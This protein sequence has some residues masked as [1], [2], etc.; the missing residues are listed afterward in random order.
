M[1][2]ILPL[3][4]VN[5]VY[6]SFKRLLMENAETEALR[7]A[8][9][10]S[11]NLSSEN[12]K[13]RNSFMSLNFFVESERI[14]KDLQ[15][16]KLKTFSE[17]GEITYS[18]DPKDIGTINTKAY[19]HNIVAKGNVYTKIVQKGTD[20][21][22]NNKMTRD[23][24]E[25][26][27]PIMNGNQ[28]IG[29]FEIYYDITVAK[30]KVDKQILYSSLIQ[31][32]VAF[33]LFFAV[34]TALLN[35]NK[36]ITERKM[37]EEKL[38]NS[39]QNLLELNKQLEKR[40][41]DLNDARIDAE[42]ANIAKSEFLANM[43]HEVR[44]PM[45]AIIGMTELTLDTD[46][47]T[48]Q[49]EYIEIVRVSSSNLLEMVNNIFDFSKIEAGKLE[50]V[51]MDFNIANVVEN[52][53][54]V[55]TL[56]ALDKGLDLT[57]HINDDLPFCLK[58]D[59]FRL[60]QIITHLVGN[61]VKFTERGKII[62]RVEKDKSETGNKDNN[63]QQLQLHFSVADTGIGIPKDKIQGIFESFS[64][65]DGTNTR[66]YGGAGLGLAIAKEL[67]HMMNGDIWVESE[68]EKGTTLHFSAQFGF[69]NEP[70]KH[71]ASTC[72]DHAETLERPVGDEIS[73][74]E[75]AVRPCP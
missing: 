64:Q 32:F 26:Y 35:A 34:I 10:L 23:V 8:T 33:S 5:I 48:E 29:A 6:P 72:I 61:A 62:V 1:T 36:N 53:V 56:Q 19:F 67:V 3:Y 41:A 70:V 42:A 16:I 54:K 74:S 71:I 51:E 63:I 49:K 18:S 65:A 50:L 24:V 21:L 14:K 27:V 46:L 12:T 11:S 2:I 17:S 9:H 52:A 55:Y 45:N 57:Y 66:E 28:F 31:L 39:N 13:L 4:N 59:S 38:H 68:P 43:S 25:T 40:Q 44:T 60:C 20:S 22:D 47:D 15:L 73:N 58:G 30:N 69:D 75:G 7:V 37:T